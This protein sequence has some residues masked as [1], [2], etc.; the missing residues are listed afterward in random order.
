MKTFS[1]GFAR[2][3]RINQKKSA[4]IGVHP[5]QKQFILFPQPSIRFSFESVI[6][7]HGDCFGRVVNGSVRA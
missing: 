4:N 1:R 5:R 6:H 2:K 7:C 3:A